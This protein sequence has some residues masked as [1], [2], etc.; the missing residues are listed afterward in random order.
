MYCVNK[1]EIFRRLEIISELAETAREI[2]ENWNG[3]RLY[4][5]AQE[6]L[7]HLAIET[8]TD[9]GNFLI[10]GFIMRDPSSYFDI[11]HIMWDEKVLDDSTCDACIRLISLRKLLV[12]N[13]QEWQRTSIH[14]LMLE[15][16]QL[17]PVFSP[18]ILAYMARQLGSDFDAF[19]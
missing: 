7:L 17:L 4:H 19:V 9:I 12:H 6:R 14:P 10:D 2:C 13:Y 16:P 15:L 8:I 18:Q 11:I 3:E 1:I 5:F